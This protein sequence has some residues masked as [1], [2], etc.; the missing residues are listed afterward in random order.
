MRGYMSFHTIHN[1]QRQQNFHFAVL[2][3]VSTANLQ[4]MDTPTLLKM[5][6]MNPNNKKIWEVAYDEEYGLENLP[7]WT[8]ISESEFRKIKHAVGNSLP[9]I[10]IFI[11][12]YDEHVA[13]KRSK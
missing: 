7:A 1:N 11:I 3:H 12:K 9:T 8:S 6:T 5:N 13:P 4:N 10:V 2:C